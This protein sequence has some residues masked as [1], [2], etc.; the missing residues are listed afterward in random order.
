MGCHC[1]L[2]LKPLEE[3]KALT[4]EDQLALVCHK[5]WFMEA[6]WGDC[7]C[8]CVCAHRSR[9]LLFHPKSEVQIWAICL[10]LIWASRTNTLQFPSLSL[11]DWKNVTSLKN[12]A[13]LWVDFLA[14]S[15][16]EGPWKTASLSG[17]TGFPGKADASSKPG[18]GAE[19]DFG[20]DCT[21]F[22]VQSWQPDWWSVVVMRGLP[23]LEKSSNS[24][25]PSLHHGSWMPKLPAFDIALS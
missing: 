11:T 13:D 23:N 15:G 10:P 9:F 20:A 3:G 22:L 1:L 18:L 2:W 7:M 21:S 6:I 16:R 24:N 14:V 19:A 4:R 17:S 12:R 5:L 8:V 25:Y